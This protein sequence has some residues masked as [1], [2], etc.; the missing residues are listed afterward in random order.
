MCGALTRAA[1]ILKPRL[2]PIFG[3]ATE[4]IRIFLVSSTLSDSDVLAEPRSDVDS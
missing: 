1:M 4:K 2:L 3:T